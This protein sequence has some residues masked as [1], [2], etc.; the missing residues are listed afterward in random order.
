M[1]AQ[2]KLTQEERV[3]LA[4]FHTH[5]Y[6]DILTIGRQLGLSDKSCRHAVHLLQHGNFVKKR[7]EHSVHVTDHGKKLCQELEADN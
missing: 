3:L 4:I 6:A 7:D 1:S 5:G 2:K